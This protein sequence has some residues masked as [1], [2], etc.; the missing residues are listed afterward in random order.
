MFLQFGCM[1]GT[2]PIGYQSPHL[3]GGSGRFPQLIHITEMVLRQRVLALNLFLNTK[4]AI[5]MA[6]AK[7]ALLFAL[8]FQ[9]H[10]TWENPYGIC[11]SSFIVWN[12]ILFGTVYLTA[13]AWFVTGIFNIWPYIFI[14]NQVPGV[15]T[16]IGR[17]SMTVVLIGL[18]QTSV[19]QQNCMSLIALTSWGFNKLS[20]CFSHEHVINN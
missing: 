18:S 7:P 20:L 1:E 15:S 10:D 19:H 5:W 14:L 9:V 8:F 6:H 16:E 3:Y 11:P 13:N 2:T 4:M 12:F 17:V